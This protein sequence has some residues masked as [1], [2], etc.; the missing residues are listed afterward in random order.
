[1]LQEGRKARGCYTQYHRIMRDLLDELKSRGARLAVVASSDVHACMHTIGDTCRLEH[2]KIIEG[3]PW[4][5]PCQVLKCPHA[6]VAPH[7]HGSDRFTERLTECR[8]TPG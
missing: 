7:C 2:P 3:P 4:W 8:S 5:L 6:P 1:M